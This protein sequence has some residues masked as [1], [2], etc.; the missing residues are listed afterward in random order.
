MAGNLEEY[1]D[2]V[3]QMLGDSDEANPVYENGFLDSHIKHALEIYSRYLPRQA[4]S[5]VAT[6]PGS[7]AISLAGIEANASVTGVE[8]P[9]DLNPPCLVPFQI[10]EDSLTL[11]EGEL[12]DGGCARLFYTLPHQVDEL[13]STIP[14]NHVHLN[15]TGAAALVAFREAVES[16][17]RVNTGGTGTAGKYLEWAGRRL[18]WYTATLKKLAR[19]R[20]LKTGRL[21]RE[22]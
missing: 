1:R 18:D 3:R 21:Y 14:E 9:T 19:H 8:Y 13:G 7:F 22:G 10:W 20:T 4:S 15:A 17:N 5:D 2:L 11:L 12:P 6:T 16:V